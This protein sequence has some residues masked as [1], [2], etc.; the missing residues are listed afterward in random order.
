MEKVLPI[1]KFTVT[2]NKFRKYKKRLENYEN[3]SWH[4]WN[5]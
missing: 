1:K 4:K 2:L 3:K 5:G